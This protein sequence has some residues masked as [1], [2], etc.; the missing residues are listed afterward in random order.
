M[1]PRDD[2]KASN[3]SPQGRLVLVL[4]GL[5]PRLRKN[6]SIQ[7]SQVFSSLSKRKTAPCS[8]AGLRPQQG[9]SEGTSLKQHLQQLKMNPSLSRLFKESVHV[10]R[11]STPTIAPKRLPL[12]LR[13]AIINWVTHKSRPLLNSSTLSLGDLHVD[14]DISVLPLTDLSSAATL[15]IPPISPVKAAACK[16]LPAPH[17]HQP[18]G[19]ED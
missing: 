17:T 19:C 12:P 6:R 3:S 1:K 4:T 18:A 14:P 10:K 8:A 7:R 13:K 16:P 5:P 2:Q 9:K 15:S 11:L